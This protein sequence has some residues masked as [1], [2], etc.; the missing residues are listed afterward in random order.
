M[1]DTYYKRPT[2]FETMD[3]TREVQIVDFKNLLQEMRE[4]DIETAYDETASENNLAEAKRL[5][6]SLSDEDTIK[7][8]IDYIIKK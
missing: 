5:L 4:E 3:K 8:L 2:N 6:K 7:L 1:T